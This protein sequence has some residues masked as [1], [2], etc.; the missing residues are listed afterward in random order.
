MG[1]SLDEV[2]SA[3]ERILFRL[4]FEIGRKAEI[5]E[6]VEIKALKDGERL[7]LIFKPHKTRFLGIPR[8]IV[9]IYCSESLHE[10]IHERIRILRCGG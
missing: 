5:G 2:V 3:F 10:I 8:T 6:V 9:E 4:N 7:K 1:M